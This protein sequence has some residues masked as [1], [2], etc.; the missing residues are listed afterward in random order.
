MTTPLSNDAAPAPAADFADRLV[1]WQRVHGR[2]DLPWQRDRDPYRVWLSEIML[3]Q[4]QVSAVIPYYE[5]FLARFPDV[6][7]LADA[8]LDDVL[9]AWSGLGYYARARN[10]HA[11]AR[12]IAH[13]LG[14]RFPETADGWAAL[15]G[16][17]RSTAAAVAVFS[18]GV[19]AAILDGNVKRVLARWRGV[20]GWPGL[21]AVERMLWT[22]AEALLPRGDFDPYT[23]GLMDLGSGLCTRSR[24]RCDACP[25]RDDCVARRDGRTSELPAA[26]PRKTAPERAIAL[27]ILLREGRVLL[28]RRPPAGIWGGLWSLPEVETDADV[29]ATCERRFGIAIESLHPGEAFRHGFTHFTLSIRPWIVQVADGSRAVSEPA[30]E[31]FE[32]RDALAAGLPKP[33]RTLLSGIAV[34]DLLVDRS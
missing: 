3:Q 32:L 25:V 13:D 27:V 34:E 33:V 31:W 11:A 18:F 20:D 4:T 12:V 26:R 15:P 10:L 23:Q 29:R 6:R 1:A 28:E 8:P 30:A 9:A 22:L 21:P 19:R 17:G 14:G 2:H 16:V 5:R 7:A 24:P